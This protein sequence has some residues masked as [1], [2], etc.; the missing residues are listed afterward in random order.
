MHEQTMKAL[1]R[2]DEVAEILS[3]SRRTVYRLFAEGRLVGHSR[4]PGKAG[5]RITAWSVTEF[6]SKYEFPSGY[7]REN[8][9]PIRQSEK[10]IYVTLSI[11]DQSLLQPLRRAP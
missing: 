8:T 5:M 2:V 7:F 4:K 1:Y 6:I 11:I 10:K 3:I 9:Y